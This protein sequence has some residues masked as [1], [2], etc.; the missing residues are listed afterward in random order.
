MAYIFL[1]SCVDWSQLQVVVLYDPGDRHA[2]CN[3]KDSLWGSVAWFCVYGMN[4]MHQ[5]ASESDGTHLTCILAD[6]K[7]LDS[8]RMQ[9][10]HIQLVVC[11]TV[12]PWVVSAEK[13]IASMM[14]VYDI[15]NNNIILDIIRS[16]HLSWHILS[17]LCHKLLVHEASEFPPSRHL[18]TSNAW[19]IFQ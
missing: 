18:E 3:I 19:E 9:Q 15:R 2:F 6:R 7:H 4:Y 5:M 1:V 14:Y 10:G 12:Y 17:Q 8:P 13:N 16:P 11:R